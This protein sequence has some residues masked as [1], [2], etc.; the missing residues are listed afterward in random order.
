ML[1]L[2][3]YINNKL[4]KKVDDVILILDKRNSNQI[5]FTNNN[6]TSIKSWSN[7]IISV[8]CSINKKIIVTNLEDFKKK[9]VND[10]IKNITKFQKAVKP[11]EDYFGIAKGPFKYKK[12]EGTF[13]K[14]IINLRDKAAD[15]VEKGINTAL[16][17]KAERCSGLFEYGNFERTLLTSNN[18]EAND[19]GTSFYFSIR[20]FNKDGSG[21]KVSCG[22]LIKNLK[23]GS[24]AKEAALIAKDSVNAQNIKPGHYDI[25]FDP[26]PFANL[27]NHVAD[28]T[29]IASV[30]TGFSFLINKLNN[31]VASKNFT[32]I[33]NATMPNSYN[34]IKFDDE[35]T[36]TKKNVIIDKGV[37]KT[38]LYNTSY[39]KKYNKKTTANAGLIDPSPW[40]IILKKGDYSKEELI[41]EVKKGLYITNTWYTRFQNYV[42]GDFS[43]MPRDGIFFIE[44]GKIKNPVKD[45][46]VSDNLLNILKN[47]SFIGNKAEQVV[48]WEVEIPTITPIVLS[49]NIN[50]TRSTS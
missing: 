23:V 30:E 14:K 45:I 42:K 6:I 34:S 12:I 24:T 22:R 8:F 31:K 7:N 3:K 16:N 10:L 48:G 18:V 4:K 39:A 19:K 26:M 44:N 38:Y 11:K 43:T 46:R 5:K 27:L 13:D 15:L 35:G 28:A 40:N 50:I 20:A 17:Y 32:L 9:G 25:I 37:L 21:H 41:K 2:L 36:P 33:D 47:T 29:S 1:S 49:K